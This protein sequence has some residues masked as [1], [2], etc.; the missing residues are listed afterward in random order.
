MCTTAIPHAEWGAFLESFTSRHK[1]W[2]VS[3]ETHDLQTGEIV[4]SRFVRLERVE[5]DLEDENNHRIN[6]RVRDDHKEIKHILFRPSDVMLQLSSAGNDESL[7][8]VSVNTVT[9][10]RFRVAAAPEAVDDVA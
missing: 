9:S 5:L 2:L 10:V 8:I 1:G 4:S 7:R 6:V 3:I